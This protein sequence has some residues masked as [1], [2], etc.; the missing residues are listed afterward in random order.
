MSLS[1][2]IVII[3]VVLLVGFYLIYIFIYKQNNRMADTSCETDQDCLNKIS[4]VKSEQP[5]CQK[6][7]L[8]T[9]KEL[10]EPSCVCLIP[11]MQY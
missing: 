9:G 4:C 11:G 5:S 10:P 7:N 2:K 3:A 1:K 6:I 8:V